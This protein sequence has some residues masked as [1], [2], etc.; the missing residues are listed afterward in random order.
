MPWIPNSGLGVLGFSSLLH[1][2]IGCGI[3]E[4]EGCGISETEQWDTHALYLLHNARGTVLTDEPFVLLQPNP[5]K[6]M[7]V[8]LYALQ[9][10]LQHGLFD[11]RTLLSEIQQHKFGAIALRE[12]GLEARYRGH[13]LFWPRLAQTITDNYVFAS[14]VGPPYVMLPKTE[15]SFSPARSHM[16]PVCGDRRGS[17][18]SFTDRGTSE[19]MRDGIARWSS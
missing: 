12:Q 4:T 13:L 2:H 7:F 17:H 6:V 9:G 3:S 16:A 18:P 11:D 5:R 15:R 1:G 8:E 10:M 14:G 19:Q